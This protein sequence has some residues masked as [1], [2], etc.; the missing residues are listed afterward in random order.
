MEIY[1]RHLKPGGVLA[2]QATNRFIN[3]API[4]ASLAAEFG[5]EAVLVTDFPENEEGPNYWTAST[6]QVLVTTNRKLLEADPIH[7]VATEISVP[8]GFRV[9]TDDFNNLLRVLK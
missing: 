4:V 1:L 2:F 3:I 8:P 5:L 9:W 7:S 6:D